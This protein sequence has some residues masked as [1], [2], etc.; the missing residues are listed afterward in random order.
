MKSLTKAGAAKREFVTNRCSLKTNQDAIVYS[1]FEHFW[2][3]ETGSENWVVHKIES[4]F[5]SRLSHLKKFSL[6]PF[7]LSLIQL[8]MLN[9]FVF[10][11]RILSPIAVRCFQGSPRIIIRTR[12]AVAAMKFMAWIYPS[13]LLYLWPYLFRHW[14][15]WHHLLPSRSVIRFGLVFQQEYSNEDDC[16]LICDLIVSKKQW[17]RL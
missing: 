11:I 14:H 4:V 1:L 10:T 16:W 8:S 9:W 13:L 7:W 3:T 5:W 17:I 15:L 2:H 6:D 12:T